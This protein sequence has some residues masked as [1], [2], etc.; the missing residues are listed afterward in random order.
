[1]EIH[2]TLTQGSSREIKTDIEPLDPQ[3]ALRQVAALPV[4]RWSYKADGSAIRHLGPMAEDFHRA[5]GLGAD[6]RHIAPGDQAGVALLA[7]QGLNQIVAEKDRQIAELAA[8]VERLEA[9][10]VAFAPAS[11]GK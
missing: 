4:A 10:V 6:D 7:V 9:L 1:M 5:F 11:S 2:G 3:A 8:R